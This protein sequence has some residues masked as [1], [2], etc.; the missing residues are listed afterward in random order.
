MSWE[1]TVA[2]NPT[3]EHDGPIARFGFFDD[4]GIFLDQ[5]QPF[6]RMG[7]EPFDIL[8]LLGCDATTGD[9]QCGIGQTCYVDPDSVTPSGVCI[10]QDQEEQLA[11][12][13][14]EQYRSFREYS[15]VETKTG[16]VT[17][18]ERA[19]VLATSPVEGCTSTSQCEDLYQVA[20]G[21]HSDEHP[22]NFV[23]DPTD[24]VFSWEC[25]ADPSRAAGTDRC[26][27]VCND[28]SDCENGSSCSAGVCVAAPLP[29]KDCFPTLQ[30][31]LAA[32]EM[33]IP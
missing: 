12:Q 4:N 15:I 33:H 17:L 25:R 16:E 1:G 26:V 14:K 2:L 22:G 32:W 6:C 19:L 23:A 7:L 8:Q 30:R 11:L 5:S 13:C 28:T 31:Y 20:R 18:A 27:M 29:S 21:I 10:P 9:A 24:P 3:I